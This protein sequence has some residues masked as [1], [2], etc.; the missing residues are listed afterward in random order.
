MV[1]YSIIF[2]TVMMCSRISDEYREK[3]KRSNSQT[4]YH[5]EDL[6]VVQYTL[7]KY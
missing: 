5:D 7:Y 2:E 6:S 1:R 3:K 4:Y